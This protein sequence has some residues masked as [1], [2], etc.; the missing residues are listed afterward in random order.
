MRAAWASV[1]GD[2]A[3]FARTFRRAFGDCSLN[4]AR[5]GLCH[6]LLCAVRAEPDAATGARAAVHYGAYVYRNSRV[7]RDAI[8]AAAPPAAPSALWTLTL[9]PGSRARGQRHP[10][11][12][13][14]PHA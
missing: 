13:P 11:P 9:P 6:A 5:A 1:R 10:N 4:P 2:E 14:N 7:A 12:D 8:A 3:S